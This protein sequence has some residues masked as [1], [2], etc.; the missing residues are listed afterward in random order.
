MLNKKWDIIKNKQ[1]DIEK[2]LLWRVKKWEQTFPECLN[3]LDTVVFTY[4][5]LINPHRNVLTFRWEIWSSDN[6]NNFSQGHWASMEH[7]FNSFHFISVFKNEF[8][9]SQ[10]ELDDLVNTLWVCYTFPSY[11][12][13]TQ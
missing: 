8:S 13:S 11:Q 10:T 12:L 9:G 4:N 5:I 6:L 1:G 2:I 3:E 7:H